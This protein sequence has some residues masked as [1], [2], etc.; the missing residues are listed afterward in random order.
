[1][2][3]LTERMVGAMKGDVKTFTEIENDPTAMG[4]AITVIVLAGVAAL[5]GNFFRAGVLF[6]VMN[7][8]ITLCAT[9]LWAL[10]VV[11]VGTKLMP[12]PTTKADFSE[13]GKT[14]ARS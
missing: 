9:A 4:Q 7:L 13:F 8:V 6:G 14:I 12:E 11:L 5:I 2:A 10:V 1:M 3:S